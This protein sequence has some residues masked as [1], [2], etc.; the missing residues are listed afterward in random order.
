MSSISLIRRWSVF[1]PLVTE[2]GK[3][4]PLDCENPLGLIRMEIGWIP[5]RL[6]DTTYR[7][8]IVDTAISFGLQIRVPRSFPT[9]STA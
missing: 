7:G 9:S 8:P 5:R 6:S 3:Y 1:G 2:P 4:F